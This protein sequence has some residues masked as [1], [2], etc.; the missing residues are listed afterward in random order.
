[1]GLLET[2]SRPLFLNI[3]GGLTLTM[4]LVATIALGASFSMQWWSFTDGN[5][6][7]TQMYLY[8]FS[9]ESCVPDGSGGQYCVS[10]TFYSRAFKDN[11]NPSDK[12]KAFWVNMTNLQY[13]IVSL[14]VISWIGTTYAVLFRMGNRPTLAL[15][16]L[17]GMTAVQ[18][19]NMFLC[20][21]LAGNY[22]AAMVT[23]FLCELPGVS[24]SPVTKDTVCSSKLLMDKKNNAKWGPEAG[25]GAVQ[26]ATILASAIALVMSILA[27]LLF[28]QYLR[29]RRT[30]GHTADGSVPPPPMTSA[31][32]PPSAPAAS[33]GGYEPA[34]A[35]APSDNAYGAK[36]ETSSQQ[37]SVA[38]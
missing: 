3:M 6:P 11:S 10:T 15:F 17:L 23:D 1:M 25:F 35:P 4:G 37:A 16:T 27:A 14:M 20:I 31:Y 38:I 28:G 8:P 13:V 9:M 5:S 29:N 30:G 34:A 7:A 22:S 32:I 24:N 18:I 12:A 33:Y 36:S 21:G 26:L 19:L 2:A